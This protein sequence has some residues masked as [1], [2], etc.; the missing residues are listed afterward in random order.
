MTEKAR[1]MKLE[2]L[3][4]PLCYGNIE[5]FMLMTKITFTLKIYMTVVSTIVT[6]CRKQPVLDWPAYK[7]FPKDI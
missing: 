6:E 7:I 4:N 1:K 5:T 3:L 2:S